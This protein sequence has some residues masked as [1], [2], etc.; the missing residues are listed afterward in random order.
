MS[1]Y[2]IEI[3]DGASRLMAEA[4]LAHGVPLQEAIA[5]ALWLYAW[6]VKQKAE[7]KHLALCDEV[8][9]TYSRVELGRWRDAQR[10]HT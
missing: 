4:A 8:N 9:M 7:G 2:T 6:L 5:Q 10:D 1:T 3:S